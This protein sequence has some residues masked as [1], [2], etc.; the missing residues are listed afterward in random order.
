[1]VS[2]EKA[3]SDLIEFRLSDAT[4]IA[5]FVRSS[6]EDLKG[7]TSS[8]SPLT[9]ETMPSEMVKFLQFIE[10]Y[11]GARVGIVSVGPERNETLLL[12]GII[13][14]IPRYA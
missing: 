4:D 2:L 11:T 13:P 1:M 9:L 5:V 12:P 10:S 8:D 6:D 3:K 14:S 7:W